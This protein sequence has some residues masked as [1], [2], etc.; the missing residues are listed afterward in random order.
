MLAPW[1][2]REGGRERENER[3]REREKGY[4]HRDTETPRHR[5]TEAQRHRGTE[6]QRH[7]GTAQRHRKKDGRTG[8][9]TGRQKERARENEVCITLDKWPKYCR[10]PSRLSLFL[11]SLL[12]CIDPRKACSTAKF[13]HSH[14]ATFK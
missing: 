8:R 11:T 12:P 13:E 6:T 10:I 2:E 7:R 1:K 5:D 14:T 4:R 3:T 9:E